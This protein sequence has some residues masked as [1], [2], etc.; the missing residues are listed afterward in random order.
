MKGRALSGHAWATGGH[1]EGV[2]R[3]STE[4]LEEARE[5]TSGCE[6]RQGN[7]D[8]V[9]CTYGE[10]ME[11]KWARLVEGGYEEG[12]AVQRGYVEVCALQG[13]CWEGI[14]RARMGAGRLRHDLG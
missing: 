1:G 13:R 7:I 4:G 14:A 5:A 11:E 2:G 6:G 3:E 10:Y 12:E 9:A 8:R